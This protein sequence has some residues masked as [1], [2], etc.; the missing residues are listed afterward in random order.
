M[1]D[2][3]KKLQ[4]DDYFEEIGV[5]PHKNVLSFWSSLDQEYG[6]TRARQL[7]SAYIKL[8]EGEEEA[9]YEMIFEEYDVGI[10]F[11][12]LRINLYKAFLNWFTKYISNDQGTI[13]D[14]GCGN[15]VLTCLYAKLYPGSKIVG[16]DRSPQAI[17]CA[18]ILKKRLKLSN[19]NFIEADNRSVADDNPD[20]K[21]DI[22]ISVASLDPVPHD[23]ASNNQSIKQLFESITGSK[24]EPA[25]KQVT[26]LLKD[27]K[28]I[29]ITFDKL[30]NS[31]EQFKRINDMKESGLNMDYRTSSW[32][33]YEDIESEKITLPVLV[34]R[35]SKSDLQLED[36]V[37]FLL[38]K[39]ESVVNLNLTEGL[40]LPA[41]ILFS[42]INPKTFLRG[43]KA[44]Y[45][46]GTGSVWHEVWQA[47]PIILILEHTNHGY[48]G[49]TTLSLLEAD[50]AIE[51]HQ[52][53]I[54]QSK[55][56]A[57]I[58]VLEKPDVNFSPLE[59]LKVSL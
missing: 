50:K 3:E 39:V 55:N 6:M 19:V 45:R 10:A 38:K 2:T 16:T 12:G 11:A 8:E 1:S 18:N 47:G 42:Y 59:S 58:V 32:I 53:W 33:T 34:A 37:A 30:K 5:R 17:N 4:V 36:A 24:P 49:L 54:E 27:E 15:G 51:K 48:R 21:G 56:Y 46:D 26:G 25:I 23:T 29:F 13:V 44:E 14:I 20:L 7:E 43:A 22:V 57:D 52:T 9:F 28:S 31:K 40:E 41:E 35:R